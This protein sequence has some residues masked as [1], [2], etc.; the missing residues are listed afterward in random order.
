[1]A[2]ENPFE[3]IQQF[4]SEFKGEINIINEKIDIALQIEYFDMSKDIKKQDFLSKIG[5]ASCRE[6]VSL[7]V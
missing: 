1:M 4:L 6:R 7:H 3:H 5:R 2:E